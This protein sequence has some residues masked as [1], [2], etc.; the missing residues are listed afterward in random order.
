MKP[1]NDRNYF[2]W[3]NFDCIFLSKWNNLKVE[4]VIPFKIKEFRIMKSI[5]FIEKCN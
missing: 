1:N 4:A 3:I 2:E 5:I